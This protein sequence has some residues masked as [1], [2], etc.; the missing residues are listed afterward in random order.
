M[1]LTDMQP[2]VQMIATVIGILGGFLALYKYFSDKKP[3]SV[4]P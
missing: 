3:E 4:S 2:L 1:A